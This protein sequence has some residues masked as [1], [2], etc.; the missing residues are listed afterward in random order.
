MRVTITADGEFLSG[1]EVYAFVMRSSDGAF[2]NFY[3]HSVNPASLLSWS[4]RGA[5]PTDLTQLRVLLTEFS[6]GSVPFF[7]E[8]E[9]TFPENREDQTGVAVYQIFYYNPGE[10]KIIG[11]EEIVYNPA[12]VQFS[13]Y[14]ARPVTLADL[15]AISG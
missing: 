6:L 9:W 7:Y 13:V 2:F 1:R 10:L 15:T 5:F 8:Y 4:Q 3:E 12:S 14:E 11:S